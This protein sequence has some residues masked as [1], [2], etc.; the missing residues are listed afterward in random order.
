MPIDSNQPTVQ[1]SAGE[2]DKK[3][4]TPLRRAGRVGLDLINP[5]SDL[6]VI[7]RTGVLPTVA[8]FELLRK[9]LTQPSTSQESVSWAQAVQHS[10]K[11]VDKL[12]KTFKTI[13]AAWWFLMAVPGIL[14]VLLLLMLLATKLD[15][16]S[17]T[18]LRAGMATLVLL[19]LSGV[20]FVKALIATYRL[21]QLETQR[22]SLEEQGTFKD[23]L[24]ET[25]WIR[26]VLSL[27]M[28]K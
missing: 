25:R 28:A 21:W 13:R 1:A 9:M 6:M 23:F 3:A 16:P 19:G 2:H 18:L 15:L 17:G 27:G 11:P 24:S 26:Q 8:R 20:G 12:R 14:A 10:G 7:Y 4:A 22:V 5:F